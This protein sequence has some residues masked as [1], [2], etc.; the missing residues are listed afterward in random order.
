MET[1]EPRQRF[2][3][4][5]DS[6]IGSWQ[7]DE[8][9]LASVLDITS[10]AIISVDKAQSIGSFN[11]GAERIFG[12]QAEEVI[13][14]AL[15]ILLPPRLIEAHRVHIRD[16]AALPVGSRRM[17]K[18][19]TIFGRRKN[20]TEFPADASI[21]IIESNGQK[22]FTVILRDITEPK[23][24]E[25]EIRRLNEELAG[26]VVELEAA[27]QEL[28]SFAYSIAHDLRAP[29]RAIDGFSRILLEDHGPHI[30][31]EPKR[32]LQLVRDNVHRMG[33]LIDDLL[34]FSRLSRQSLELK[35][36][37]LGKLVH[38]ALA[39]L[40]GEQQGRR[41]EIS[42]GDLPVCQADPPMLTQVFINLLDNAFKYTRKR[43]VAV[44]E[45]GC[46]DA[47]DKQGEP[48]CCVKDNGVGFDMRYV[49]KLF[50]VFQRLHPSDEYEGTGVGLAMVQRVIHRHGGRVW[51]ES[52]VDK[53]ATFYFTLGGKP[54]ND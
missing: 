17:G 38:Q 48:V 26:R 5:E 44:I 14:K 12:Y 46:R 31:E 30:L 34:T 29:L 8:P 40:R 50:G 19:G 6:A 3:D 10:D 41:V 20:G 52:E 25:E 2:A 35:P 11:L 45:I 27:N 49:D 15:D 1:A 7:G 43:D 22:L 24:A 21:S 28:E 33:D 47:G 16:L 13:G 9:L 36:V 18:R 51:A 39:D 54:P 4:L 23:R 37:A 42:V 53:G 32:Y